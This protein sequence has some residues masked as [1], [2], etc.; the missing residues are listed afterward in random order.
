MRNIIGH[1]PSRS[2]HLAL[3]LVA[4]GATTVARAEDWPSPGLDA[5]HSRLS[6]ERSGSRFSDG[7]WSVPGVGRVLASP[8]VADGFLVTADLEGSVRAVRADDGQLAW[9]VSLA[10]TVQGTPAIAR[11]RVFVPTVANKV[12][13]LRLADG[14]RLWSRDVGG[15]VLSSPASVGS[16]LV[17]AGGFPSKSVVRLSG[18]T[19]EIVW[20]SPPIMD[21]FSNTAPAVGGGLVVVGSQGGRYY[22]F[23]AGTGEPRWQH[24][25]DGV[26]NL[27]APLI[28][29]G[30]VYMAGGAK[31]NRVHAV[32]A[33]TGTVAP[34]WPIDLPSPD[35]DMAGTVKARQRGVSS[36][37]SAGGLLLLQTRLDDS[38]DT[39]ANGAADR[40]LSRESVVG[41]D[42]TSGA[43]R[44][45]RTV[46]RAEFTDPNDVPKFYICPTPAAFAADD[47]T[48]LMAAASSIAPAVV[49][50]DL[51]QGAELS[52]ISVSGAAL[53][54]P[55]LANGRLISVAIDGSIDSIASSANHAPAAPVLTGYARPLDAGD[56]TLRWLPGSDPDAEVPGYEVRIDSDGEVLETW[57]HEISV[58]SGATSLALTVPLSVGVTYS[59]A[60]R[61][62]DGRGA[63][64]AWSLPETF[65]VIVNPT[66]TVG[67]NA[68]ASLREAAAVAQP[69]DT[70]M[71][72]SGTYTLTQTLNI[73]AGVT[74]QGS[75]AGKTTIDAT[76]LGVGINFDRST[77]GRP[78]R[79]EGITVAGAETCVQIADGVTGV[80]IRRVIIRDCR[81]DGVSVRAGGA[82]AIVNAT[83]VG[84]GTAVHAAGTAKI[85]NSLLTDNAVALSVDAPGS[86]ASTY[87][88]LFGNPK[89]YV[90]LSAGAG[91]FSR[92]VA[93][94]DVKARDF[95]LASAQPSTDKG[96]PADKP[97]DEPA[98][99]G[100]RINLGAFGGTSEAERT[101]ESTAIAGARPG[102]AAPASDQPRPAAA[103]TAA[104]DVGE[105]GHGAC[106]IAGSDD[107]GSFLSLMGLLT[108]LVRRRR[109]R[110]W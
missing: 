1:P 15:M 63:L 35:P 33:A 53:A 107:G 50:L 32:D 6:S 37:A 69:G 89:D 23:D 59:Y 24:T 72:G 19:G 49:V 109:G 96:D 91:D 110:W 40:Y 26:V 57:Q 108:L 11:G 100:G 34:G 14:T 10:S 9:Q 62:R 16:D 93:F 43:I 103:S 88:D 44:W 84:S 56:V 70:I 79:L 61:A 7:R 2:I 47:R 55:V 54:S 94:A 46:A 58:K 98:P 97:G 85:K 83:F 78:S 60:V 99:N 104:P 86:L 18:A 95:R 20:Q 80:D 92:P 52:R 38:L 71:L 77:P 21:Q 87:N 45:Q 25:A 68:V 31:S 64:S 29:G 5:G 36:I 102:A 106:R 101:E 17:L 42:P 81:V 105:E 76:R 65:S 66:V 3:I 90:G 30:R 12:I 41:L 73:G 67:G 48:S 51:V 13:A 82:A 39:D 28:T 27:A 74:F 22:A 8:V 4:T 75:G